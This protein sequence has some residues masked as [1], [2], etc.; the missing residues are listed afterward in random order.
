MCEGEFFMGGINWS[1]WIDD[2]S[3]TL[4]SFTEGERKTNFSKWE[5]PTFTA[6]VNKGISETDPQKRLEYWSQAE[7]LLI[8]HVPVIPMFYEFYR[9]AK[10]P[11]LQNTLIFPSQGIIDFKYSKICNKT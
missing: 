9:Y 4:Q 1:T 6:L 8:E 11:Y 10:S 7:R 5:N 3:Y 2:P